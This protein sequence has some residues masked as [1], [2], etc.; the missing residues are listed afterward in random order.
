MPFNLTAI[1]RRTRNPRRRVIALRP[2]IPTGVQGVDLYQAAYRPFVDAWAATLDRIMAEYRRSLSALQ[3]DSAGDLS[4]ILTETDGLITRLLLAV[5]P[6]LSQRLAAFGRWHQLKWRGAVLSA[7]GVDLQTLIGPETA[8]ETLAQALERNVGLIRSVSDDARR[9]ISDI[10]FAGLQQ[11]R[12][13]DDVARDLRDSV[14]FERKRARRVAGDQIVKLSSALDRERRKE[15]GLDV[16]KW[17]HSAKLHPRKW[18]LERNG[19]LFTDNPKKVGTEIDGETV[20]QDPAAE[21][22]PGVPPFCGCV[23]QAVL[24]FD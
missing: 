20:R 9:K 15:A 14:D 18:H 19:H 2:I 7:T 5:R 4:L 13:A 23:A 10:V 22:M 11:R 3:T 8:R 17:H 24:T 12:S 16:W 1:T 6:V 21:D